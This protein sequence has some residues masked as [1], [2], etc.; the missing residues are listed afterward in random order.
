[1]KDRNIICKF[2]ER[3]GQC[4]KGKEADLSGYCVH[5]GLYEKKLGIRPFRTDD[6]RRKL[7][8]INKKERRDVL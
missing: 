4:K 6:R 5:C 3:H 1:M 2:Y 8:K 7:E